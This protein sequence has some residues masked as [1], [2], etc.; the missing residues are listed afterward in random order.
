MRIPFM[1]LLHAAAPLALAFVATAPATAATLSSPA[2]RAIELAGGD[3]HD[4][5][6]AYA[7][8]GALRSGSSSSVRVRAIADPATGQTS[9]RTLTLEGRAR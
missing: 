6:F 2:R 4:S 5:L 9:Q 8:N 1:P 7:A 3:E